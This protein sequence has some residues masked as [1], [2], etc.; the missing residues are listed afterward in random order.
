MGVLKIPNLKPDVLRDPPPAIAREPMRG[1]LE[2]QPL[3]KQV[4]ANATLMNKFRAT[5]GCEDEARMRDMI[6]EVRN[7]A[8]SIDP[9]LTYAE[10][11]SL[12]LLLSNTDDRGTSD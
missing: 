3:A 5:I 9:T 10:G 1:N 8:R 4:A 6:D 11:A 7:Y 12:A 2:L